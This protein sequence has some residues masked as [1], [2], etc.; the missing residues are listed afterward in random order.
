MHSI[1]GQS[2]FNLL[3]TESDKIKFE[4][5]DNL[6]IIPVSVNGVELSF[7]LDTGVSRPILFNI[8]NFADSLQLKN[9]KTISLRGLGSDGAVSSIQS[10]KNILRIGNALS[11]NQELF[12]VFDN[13]INFTP[14]LGVPVH[15]IIGYDLLKDFVV[16]INYTRKF[17]KLHNPSTY[18]YKKCK[19]CETLALQF[20]NNKPYLKAS[21]TN[22]GIDIPL[23]LL[24][25]T[26]GSDDLWLFEDESLGIVPM[27]NRFFDDYLGRGL[28]GS[29][30]GKRA[31]VAQLN[32]SSFSFNKVNAAFPDSSSIEL[33]RQVKERN[34][35]I[36][37]G[38]L[39]RFNIIFDYPASKL[40]L[41]KN[42]NF[43][44]PFSYNKSGIVLEQ[45]GFR[46][47]K[48]VIRPVVKDIYGQSN[49][50]SVV[51][52]TSVTY[53]YNLKPSFEIVQVRPNSVA[54][55]AGIKIGDVV[56]SI[57]GRETQNL[58]LQT[59]NKM[60]LLKV[61]ST[62]KMRVERDKK[63]LSFEFTLEDV[64]K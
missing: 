51:I 34:G 27:E 49:E 58:S 1:F 48:E 54:E 59:V 8:L 62:I 6:I 5:I 14:I 46:V 60:F 47:V 63:Q 36:S 29:V 30:Y 7:L 9:L 35:S 4:L 26:G 39:R 45:R 16:E 19:K 53:G 23:N 15:G 11:T 13:S 24:I 3:N 38:I 57:N 31:R 43:N 64:F 2:K 41:K 61:G 37:G 20:F 32:L 18:T 22:E 17:I 52:T 10:E 55:K 21:L 42:G 56:L 12:V 28:S 40:T 25:D 44:L 33:A 50:G